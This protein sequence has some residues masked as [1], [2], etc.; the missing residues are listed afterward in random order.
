MYL[1][2][3][4]GIKFT[5]T[6]DDDNNCLLLAVRYNKGDIVVAILE[7]LE[8]ENLLSDIEKQFFINAQNKEGNTALLEA[9]TRNLQTIT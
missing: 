1:I 5:L 9:A 8:E 4:P 7:K 2:H 6:D 3:E